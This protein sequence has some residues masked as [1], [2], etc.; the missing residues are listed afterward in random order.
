MD[1]A[2]HEDPGKRSHW[3]SSNVYIQYRDNARTLLYAGFIRYCAYA[4][5]CHVW[6]MSPRMKAVILEEPSILIFLFYLGFVVIK[7]K[8]SICC[9]FSR[10]IDTLFCSIFLRDLPLFCIP[11]RVAP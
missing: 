5:F 7:T 3:S 6:Y 9:D 2:L 4:V 8:R 10:L 1:E 11:R